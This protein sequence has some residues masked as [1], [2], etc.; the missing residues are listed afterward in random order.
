MLEVEN[1]AV[2][3]GSIAALR[4]MSLRVDAGE[5]VAL[6]GSNGAGKSTLIK[7]LAGLVVPREGDVR[8][9]GVSLKGRAAHER[10][11]AGIAV[12]PEN[13]RLFGAMTV[14]DNLLLGAYARSVWGR[15]ADCATDLAQVFHLFPRLRERERQLARTMS[16]GEQQMLA[17][18]RALMSRPQVILMDEPS[19]GLAPKIVHDIFEVIRAL[20]EQGRTIL[21]VEQ[22]AAAS[23]RIADRAYVLELGRVIIEGPA[24]AVWNMESVRNLYLGGVQE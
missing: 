7:A 1:L 18:G 2:S 21:L 13:R 9:H 3:Y 24:A 16:G 6:I 17:I 8:L 22:N 23:L 15:A 10:A 19:I 11:R 20:R 4:G 14:L 12:V 5:I